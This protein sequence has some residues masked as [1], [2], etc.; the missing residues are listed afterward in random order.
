MAGISSTGTGLPSAASLFDGT[1]TGIGTAPVA[2]VVT[3]PN[4]QQ[5]GLSVQGDFGSTTLPAAAPADFQGTNPTPLD[6]PDAQYPT[7]IQA[8]VAVLKAIGTPE[9]VIGQLA[10]SQPQAEWLDRYIQGEIMQNPEAWDSYVGDPAV[11]Q[12][13]PA[14]TARAGLQALIPGVQLP[15]PGA[16]NP[17][18]MPDG[19]AVSG[20]NVPGLSTPLLD[21]TTGQPQGGSSW[22]M[23]A[24]M[25]G[26]AAI[27]GFFLWR[28]FKNKNAATDLAKQG[29][30]ALT[31]GGA[32]ALAGGAARLPGTTS[33]FGS[34]IEHMGRQLMGAGLEAND[35]SL[36]NR[37]MSLGV[38]GAGATGG[39]AAAAATVESINAGMGAANGFINSAGI[40][41]LHFD[42]PMNQAI[43]AALADRYMGVLELATKTGQLGD[44]AASQVAM[45][46]ALTA[47]PAVAGA[48]GIG[49]E[50]LRNLLHTA[51]QAIPV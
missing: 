8:H 47:A 35:L 28:H 49:G 42:M 40:S 20:I 2:P 24:L 32:D 51:A 25:I 29:V 50:A 22:L 27:G 39:G 34:T 7:L 16:G 21:P 26:A 14:G 10:A 12:P 45:K 43:N 19:S 36:V 46:Q 44:F 6:Q 11:A 9:A 1:S 37:G 33:G 17:G 48:G 31:G 23:P 5:P 4:A 18:Y 15:A 41:A 13:R 3:D 30:Q 38:F